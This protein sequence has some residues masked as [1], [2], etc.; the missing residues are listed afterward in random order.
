MRALGWSPLRVLLVLASLALA[1]M[2]G[3]MNSPR[4]LSLVIGGMGMI[5]LVAQ[6]HLGLVLLAALSFT[7]PLEIGTGSAV[8]LTPPV[9]LIAATSA[10]WLL[11][12]LNQHSLRLP[13]WRPVLPLLLFVISGLVSLLAGRAYWDPL[14]SQPGN[15]TL[16]QLGQWGIFAL[17]ALIFVLAG[18]LGSQGRW[19]KWATFGYVAASSLVVI[20][21]LVPTLWSSTAGDANSGMLWAWLAAMAMGQLACNR[22]LNAPAKIALLALLAGGA[23]VVWVKQAEWVSGWLPFTV[24]AAAVLWLR[25]W[26]RNRAVA[27]FVGLL[28]LMA[29]V[30]VYPWVYEHSG[31]QREMA[32]SWGGRLLLYQRVLE[33]VEDHPVLGLGPAAYRHYAFTHWLGGDLGEALWIRPHVSSHNNYI[34]VY[35]QQGLV[36]LGLF[37]WF[38]VEVGRL[39]WRLMNRFRGD[40]AEGY[41]VGALSGLAA[42]LVAMMLVDWFLPFVY[43][44]GFQGFR[45]SALAWMFLGGLLALDQVGERGWNSASG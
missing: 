15:L 4:M 45:T 17:S 42:T 36:G 2:F 30:V 6:P 5:V 40:F 20:Q 44:V 22:R 12:G 24:A 25:L 28:L 19:L 32:T 38:L 7:L 14:V 29:A 34:D 23:Y 11:A 37:L 1:L 27:L 10:A 43:N 26:R 9:F 33:L 13:A 16:V 35:A 41:V 39:G 8:S 18:E 21:Y 31:G 3:T